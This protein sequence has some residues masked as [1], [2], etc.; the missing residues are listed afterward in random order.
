MNI[1]ALKAMFVRLAYLA[2]LRDPD[3]PG[4]ANWIATLKDDFSNGEDVLRGIIDSAEGTANLA[5]LRALVASN[6]ANVGI[7]KGLLGL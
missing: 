3:P 1:P 7:L 6:R 2:T 4:E 5:V